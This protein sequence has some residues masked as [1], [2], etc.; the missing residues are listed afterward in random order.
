MPVDLRIGPIRLRVFPES[1]V[2]PHRPHADRLRS[3]DV[4]DD[5]VPYMDEL[6]SGKG[7]FVESGL[8]NRPIRFPDADL[9]GEKPDIQESADPEAVLD[10]TKE[11]T[12]GPAGVRDE[13]RMV[14]SVSEGAQRLPDVRIQSR[15]AGLDCRAESVLKGPNKILS[16]LSHSQEPEVG[17]SL[18][19]HRQISE[20]VPGPKDEVR[21]SVVR[22]T[23]KRSTHREA[24]GLEGFRGPVDADLTHRFVVAVSDRRDLHERPPP[25]NLH[26][27]ARHGPS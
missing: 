1:R 8:E 9:V 5:I 23:Q 12:P 20:V 27:L 13:A 4:G 7:E 17:P 2:E 14:S 25:V 18:F 19:L 6:V 10:G 24:R 3:G 21:L 26:A 22:A 16:A 11:T 15:E